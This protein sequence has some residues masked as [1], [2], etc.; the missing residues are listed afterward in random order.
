MGQPALYPGSAILANVARIDATLLKSLRS[1]YVD[2]PD[3]VPDFVVYPGTCVL[4]VTQNSLLL[5][6]EMVFARMAAVKRGYSNHFVLMHMDG[7]ANNRFTEINTRCLM[8]EFTLVCA[9]SFA[10]VALYIEVIRT[11]DKTSVSDGKNHDFD[12]ISQFTNLLSSIRHVSKSDATSL[13]QHFRCIADLFQAHENNV[14]AVPGM[15]YTKTREFIR[16]CRNSF[17]Q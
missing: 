12:D 5:Q 1:A 13:R 8:C 6:P 11:L 7:C 15:G 2:V 10:E 9:S 4:Y 14:F 3:L 17:M 16:V